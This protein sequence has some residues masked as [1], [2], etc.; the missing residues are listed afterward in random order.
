MIKSPLYAT[1]VGLLQL[2]NI[3]K[4]ENNFLEEDEPGDRA[5]FSTFKKWLRDA[6]HFFE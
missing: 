2:G 1:G 5:I 3:R 4:Y 6:F